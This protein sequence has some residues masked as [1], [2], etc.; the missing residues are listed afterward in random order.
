MLL[1][2]SN[3][4]F[5]DNISS[6]NKNKSDI[7]PDNEKCCDYYKND[8][9]PTKEGVMEATVGNKKFDEEMKDRLREFLDFC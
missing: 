6:K 5:E 7:E 9:K 2:T 8:I 1:F 4:N 3:T